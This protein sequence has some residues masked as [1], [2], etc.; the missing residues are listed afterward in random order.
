MRA[1]WNAQYGTK[2]VKAIFAQWT[3]TALDH[4]QPMLPSAI[5][6]QPNMNTRI[7]ASE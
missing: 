1:L 6:F 7:V 4:I 3:S 2:G 5:A